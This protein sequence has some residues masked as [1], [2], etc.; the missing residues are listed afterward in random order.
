MAQQ[1]C[2]DIADGDVDRVIT[3][4]CANYNYQTEIPNPDFNPDLPVDP[5]TN[6]QGARSSSSGWF[7]KM[8]LNQLPQTLQIHKFH[9]LR[10]EF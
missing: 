1:F 9:P 7:S 2:V 10:M 6:P 8:F 4:M 5:D 3:A